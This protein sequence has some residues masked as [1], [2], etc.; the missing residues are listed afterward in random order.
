M[1]VQEGEDRLQ[2]MPWSIALEG[3]KSVDIL[4][5]RIKGQTY[6]D[7]IVVGIYYRLFD[8]EKKVDETFEQLKEA[9]QLPILVTHDR[10]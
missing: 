9:L 1:T 6:E 10:L 2:S 3:V 7:Y 8:Q 5:V 4:F